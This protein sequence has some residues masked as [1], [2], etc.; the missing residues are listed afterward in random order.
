MNLVT[1]KINREDVL[2]F[3]VYPL[4]AWWL[5]GLEQLLIFTFG[6]FAL[7]V[8]L[9]DRKQFL[10]KHESIFVLFLLSTFVSALF[11]YHPSRLLEIGRSTIA[12][13]TLIF[14]SIYI[15]TVIKTKGKKPILK[16][17]FIIFIW[18]ILTALISFFLRDLTLIAPVEVII[19]SGLKD[20]SLVRDLYYKRLG[21]SYFSIFGPFWRPRGIYSYSTALAITLVVLIP[22]MHQFKLYV[23]SQKWI[24]IS[25]LLGILVVF[26]TT[27]R[28]ALIALFV[29]YFFYGI[30]IYKRFRKYLLFFTPLVLLAIIMLLDLRQLFIGFMEIRGAGSVS[31]RVSLYTITFEYFLERPFFGWGAQIPHEQFYAALGSHSGYLNI[32]FCY[33]V[34]GFLLFFAG[35]SN[36]VWNIRFS[37]N[38]GLLLLGSWIVFFIVSFTEVFHLDFITVLV[39]TFII[40]ITTYKPYLSVYSE[41]INQKEESSS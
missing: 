25:I 30:F 6:L 5:L 19:P 38:E 12:F 29:V 13:I 20:Y 36:C 16:I 10:K 9:N 18:S 7:L 23:K 28:I 3:I 40:A 17:V 41:A 4:P 34:I 2:K 35:I 32:L 21:D 22:M 26:F 1:L 24:N 33:G 37:T 14:G 8:F 31:F 15:G 27:T 11:V 39:I